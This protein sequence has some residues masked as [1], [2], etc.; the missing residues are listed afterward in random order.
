MQNRQISQMQSQLDIVANQTTAILSLLRRYQ[1]LAQ[2]QSAEARLQAT[3]G[4]EPQIGSVDE[5]SLE[6]LTREIID[7]QR[8]WGSFGQATGH[9]A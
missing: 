5:Q 4:V 6:Q 3:L 8:H 7:S 1:A 2:V 9:G